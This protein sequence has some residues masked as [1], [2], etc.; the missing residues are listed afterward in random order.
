MSN[1]PFSLPRWLSPKV[2]ARAEALRRYRATWLPAL[3]AGLSRARAGSPLSEAQAV[4]ALASLR[5]GGFPAL[6]EALRPG[7]WQAA[8]GIPHPVDWDRE[9]QD[10]DGTPAEIEA[11]LFVAASAA[12][13]Y[14]REAAVRAF[15]RHPGRTALAILLI[16]C[17]D[18]VPEVRNAALAQVDAMLPGQGAALVSLLDLVFL[19]SSRS[20]D[21]CSE[22]AARLQ[23]RLLAADLR[24]TPWQALRHAS[25]AARRFILSLVA[26]E[27]PDRVAELCALAAGE[28]EPSL[29]RWGLDT[30]LACLPTNEVLPLI[31]L[32][33]NHPQG[34]IRAAA[35]RHQARLDPEGVRHAIGSHLFDASGAVRSAAAH[36]YR[37]R[38]GGDALSRWRA[39]VDA[40]DPAASLALTSL[41]D[42]AE[43]M[44]A[45]RLRPWLRHGRSRLRAAALRGFARTQAN[46]LVQELRRALLDP[47]PRV[48]RQARALTAALPGSL[49]AATL[50]QAFA[51]TDDAAVRASLVAA[52]RQLDKWRAL[53][54]LLSWIADK[55]AFPRQGLA[56]EI[57]RWLQRETVTFT[58]LPPELRARFP[59]LMDAAEAVMPGLAWNRLR[60]IIE[61]A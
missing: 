3:A 57:A 45:E 40:A 55:R 2:R 25:P 5:A 15:A 29:A 61:Q 7:G 47:S 9:L 39:C 35:L 23:D 34:T 31:Q 44:D 48:R 54:Q 4:A 33:M 28:R 49:D 30:A 1:P 51:A 12:S 56:E 46:D 58:P 59:A 19:L 42:Q 52:S 36:L 11:Q 32:A 50:A 26:R 24:N 21:P 53:E 41:A 43:P 14:L 17:H 37:T 8:Q 18:W 13:G 60:Y 10:L 27:A 22:L 38:F 20:R 16:R 6:E